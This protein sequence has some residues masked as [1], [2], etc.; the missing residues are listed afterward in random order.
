MSDLAILSDL[1]RSA[2]RD[3]TREVEARRSVLRNGQLQA[4]MW[5]CVVD[6]F[7]KEV[8]ILVWTMQVEDWVLLKR[9]RQTMEDIHRHGVRYPRA[10]PQPMAAIEAYEKALSMAAAASERA[11][12]KYRCEYV[13]A[14]PCDRDGSIWNPFVWEMHGEPEEADVVFAWFDTATRAEVGT[15]ICGLQGG[16]PALPER[17]DERSDSEAASEEYEIENTQEI[18]LWESIY[19]ELDKLEPLVDVEGM[20]AE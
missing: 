15:A 11:G 8:V 18:Q 2:A 16:G 9:V 12:H 17:D 7:D 6:L 3:M 14:K 1:A 4:P 13:G 10:W 5:S 19:A 20:N